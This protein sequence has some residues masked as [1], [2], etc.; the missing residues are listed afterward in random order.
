MWITE[1]HEIARKRECRRNLKTFLFVETAD[2]KKL[3]SG[4]QRDDTLLSPKC[5]IFAGTLSYCSC[6]VDGQLRKP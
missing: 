1:G 5:F 2:W 4:G 3:L 6:A